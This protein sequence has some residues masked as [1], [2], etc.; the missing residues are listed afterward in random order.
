[1]MEEEVFYEKKYTSYG[2]RSA[3]GCGSGAHESGFLGSV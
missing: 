3:D 2:A 1:M